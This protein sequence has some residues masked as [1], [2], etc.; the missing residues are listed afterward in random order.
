VRILLEDSFRSEACRS[1]TLP[2]STC[3]T[4]SAALTIIVCGGIV[5]YSIAFTGIVHQKTL[6]DSSLN[7]T[8]QLNSL[9]LLNLRLNPLL[10]STA[11]NNHLHIRRQL[12]NLLAPRLP[13]I[14]RNNNLAPTDIPNELPARPSCKLLLTFFAI[15]LAE[16]LTET[17]HEAG[18]LNAH[19]HVLDAVSAECVP[20][21][22]R[23]PQRQD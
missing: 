12:S 11:S 15:L 4:T 22:R 14:L 1:D 3:P 17:L 5:K 23:Q 18:H 13:T 19:Q 10:Q 2:F 9:A 20:R 16:A 21:A 8:S 7:P 6:L